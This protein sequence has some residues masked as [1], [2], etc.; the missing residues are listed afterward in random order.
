L[1]VPKGDILIHLLEHLGDGCPGA[2]STGVFSTAFRI[3]AHPAILLYLFLYS[4]G[5][6]PVIFL[7][8][9]RNAF[10]SV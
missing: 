2:R 8:T 6:S 4:T 1:E 9:S 5:V 10:E 3:P 7:N